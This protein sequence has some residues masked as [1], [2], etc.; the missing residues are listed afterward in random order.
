MIT[1]NKIAHISKGYKHE[2]SSIFRKVS[3]ITSSD[4]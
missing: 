3:T 1:P 2:M 4:L